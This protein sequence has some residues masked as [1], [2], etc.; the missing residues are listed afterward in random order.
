LLGSDILKHP[1]WSCLPVCFPFKAYGRPA[2]EIRP[3]VLTCLPFLK[4][5]ITIANFQLLACRYYQKQP[6]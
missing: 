5:S 1:F 4:L 3:W 2:L 6:S